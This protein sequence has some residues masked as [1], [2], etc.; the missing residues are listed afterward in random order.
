MRR[1]TSSFFHPEK[2][3]SG[4]RGKLDTRGGRG[5]RGRGVQFGRVNRKNEGKN[6]AVGLGWLRGGFKGGIQ[7]LK[8]QNCRE[9]KY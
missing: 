4:S 8:K 7:I 3:V 9:R 1:S 2:Y 6:V 5:G